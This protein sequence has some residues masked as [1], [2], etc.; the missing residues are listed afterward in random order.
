MKIITN[1]FLLKII[2]SYLI[3]K[4]MFVF[5]Q[6]ASFVLNL[7][8]V[9]GVLIVILNPFVTKLEKRLKISRTLLSFIFVS[10]TFVGFFK[11]TLF[12]VPYLYNKLNFI[13][14]ELTKNKNLTE[15]VNL[16]QLALVKIGISDFFSKEQVYLYLKD[17]I[18][19]L[20]FLKETLY[21]GINQAGN[22]ILITIITPFFTFLLLKDLKKIKEISFSL[23]S[24]NRKIKF[25]NTIN[26]LNNL[27]FTY[28]GGQ[29][30]VSIFLF[31]F[32]LILLS[33]FKIQ[34]ALFISIIFAIANFFPY[35][36]FYVGLLFSIFS[37]LDNQILNSNSAELFY[38]ISKL[39][40]II[41]SGQVIEGNFITPKIVGSKV[42]VHPIFL[43]LGTLLSVP[44]FGLF[45]LILG[46]PIT[47][48]ISYF[49]R[50]MKIK[51]A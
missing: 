19:L 15:I 8:L 20:Y 43:I 24:K 5:L 48:I 42:G 37:S 25:E 46:T 17:K 9:S 30:T 44:I 3:I 23:L 45:G 50:S 26:D 21:A 47:I 38:Y 29:F 18:D 28:W 41:F 12:V 33:I 31:F 16:S 2:L 34:G 10:L 14:N 1:S 39:L 27:I 4:E 35:I 49:I 51:N 6:Y 11:L 13:I 22:L 40:L 32:Y 36:G 7:L